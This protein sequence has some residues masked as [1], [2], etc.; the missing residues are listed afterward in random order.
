MSVAAC[1]KCAEKVLL[2]PQTPA[3]AKV[4]CPLCGENYL[5]A[6]AMSTLPPMLEVI[7]LPDGFSMPSEDVSIAAGDFR[8]SAN[9]PAAVSEDGGELKLQDEG[10]VATAQDEEARY[11]Q[12]GAVSTSTPA[13]EGPKRE[14][15]Q[16]TPRK[17]KKEGNP[18]VHFVGIVAGGLL[19]FPLAFLILLW[20]PGSWQ[21]DP[22]RLG[23]WLGRTI[24]F[25]APAN[26]RTSAAAPAD[27]PSTSGEGVASKANKPDLTS[28]QGTDKAKPAGEE[29][30]EAPEMLAEDPLSTDPPSTDPLA[31]DTDPALTL[32]D[33]E[34]TIKVPVTPLEPADDVKPD[35]A[36]T[37]PK[38]PVEDSVPES[39]PPPAPAD[40]TPESRRE[41]L[42]EADKSFNEA[43]VGAEKKSAAIAL[44]AAAAQYVATL[45]GDV[46][47]E[48]ALDAFVDDFM[49]FQFVGVYAPTWLDN[50]ERE[51]SGIVLS[52]TVLSCQAADD[53]F[54]MRV[55]LPSRD[56]R[57]VDVLSPHE[58]KEGDK[59]L[60]AGKI[61]DAESEVPKIEAVYVKT[62][63]P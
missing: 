30:R 1:P 54:E 49:K 7:E 53:R 25:L 43:A 11:D 2:P 17:K 42:A 44:Y 61:A 14:R 35:S 5:L 4:R 13:Y 41:A 18:L 59:V 3:E 20:L 47:E 10:G 56:K 38:P 39:T 50:K 26:F 34:P 21:R 60:V 23:P 9:R 46:K 63:N 8:R 22:A 16:V 29:L 6:E 27:R 45:S 55:E 31:S 51:S 24:P 12:W 48:A 15:F 36:S 52:G 40:E 28:E 19:A 32:P 33:V 58:C 57:Q 37:S 62:A